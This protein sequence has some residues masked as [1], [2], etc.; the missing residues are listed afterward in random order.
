MVR[1]SHSL[2]HIN[3]HLSYALYLDFPKT[4]EN[5]SLL[6][7]FNL[8]STHSIQDETLT[9]QT[10]AIEMYSTNIEIWIM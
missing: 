1:V 6:F 4:L 2:Y 9:E 8:K 7:T 5:V 3:I 10:Q